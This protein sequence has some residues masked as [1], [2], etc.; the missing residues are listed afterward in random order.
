[1]KVKVEVQQGFMTQGKLMEVC[2]RILERKVYVD[3]CTL[4]ECIRY[5]Q[6]LRS[7]WNY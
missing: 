1:M 3:N 4:R 2:K 5:L 6:S 7:Y